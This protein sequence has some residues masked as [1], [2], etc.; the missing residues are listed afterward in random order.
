LARR[1]IE[2]TPTFEAGQKSSAQAAIF[3]SELMIENGEN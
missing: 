1:K 3:I 2:F